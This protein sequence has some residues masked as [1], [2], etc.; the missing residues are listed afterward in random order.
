[1]IV[2]G[3]HACEDYG[4]RSDKSFR[5]STFLIF[6]FV[7][8]EQLTCTSSTLLGQG[9][10]HSGSAS[11]DDFGQEIRDK[12][13]CELVSLMGFPHN[14][15]TAWLAHSHEVF[16]LTVVLYHLCVVSCKANTKHATIVC[17]PQNS[18][19]GTRTKF[20]QKLAISSE[21]PS[22]P[23]LPNHTLLYHSVGC[24]C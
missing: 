6:I 15:R 4:K 1:M 10:F 7:S 11:W 24:V 12:L 5:T 8:G 17:F 23:P 9:S 3:A 18:P 20:N 22:P 16:F 14:T 2:C 13:V 19:S 21:S